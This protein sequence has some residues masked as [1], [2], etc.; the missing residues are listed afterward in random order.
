VNRNLRTALLYLLFI[1]LGL[2]F[3]AN[4][5]QPAGAVDELDSSHFIQAVK[6]GRVVKAEVF[7]RTMEVKGEYYPDKAAAEAKKPKKFAT[8]YLNDQAL[9]EVLDAEGT[10][11]TVNTQDSQVW[12]GLL[13]SLIPVV[14]IVLVMFWMINQMQ[15]GNSKVMSFGKARTKR[16][17]RDQPR[18]T[19]KDVAGVDE[20]V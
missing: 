10:E 7:V 9:F 20:A 13:G 15:G 6:D 3:L 8:T 12:L 17:T 19:F 2:L 18:I 5:L 4:T 14:L 1:V 11:Y 16:M